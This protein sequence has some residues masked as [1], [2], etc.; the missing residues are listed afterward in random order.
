MFNLKVS[1]IRNCPIIGVDALPIFSNNQHYTIY[2]ICVPSL[3]PLV[4]LE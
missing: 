1:H 4:R 3:T 2:E